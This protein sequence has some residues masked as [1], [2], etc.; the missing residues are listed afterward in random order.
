MPKVKEQK[1]QKRLSKKLGKKVKST[2]A[3]KKEAWSWFSKYIRLRDCLI[4]MGSKKQGKC[5]TCNKVF[6][7]NKLQAGHFIDGRGNAVLFEEDLVHSQCIQCNYFKHGNK[8][9]YEPRM[10]ELYGKAKV[11][12]FRQLRFT[13]K[14]YSRE[15]YE[16]IRDYY[17]EEYQ[18]TYKG[19]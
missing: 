13:T 18:D 14:E 8:E 17:K 6:D 7:F 19:N 4:T 1:K 12:E 5:F 2:K 10:L 11:D 15:D 3:I 9:A 16:R